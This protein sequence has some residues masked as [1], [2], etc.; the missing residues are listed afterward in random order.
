MD[1]WQRAYEAAEG[2]ATRIRWWTRYVE[3]LTRLEPDATA[4]ILDVA[5]YPFDPSQGMEALLSGA[6]FRN[7]ERAATALL[8]WDD[9]HHSSSSAL[10]AFREAIGDYCAGVNAATEES[11]RCDSLLSG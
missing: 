5:L 4:K 1:W 9:E 6:N 7:L 10:A 11:G 2:P 3:A 8:Q